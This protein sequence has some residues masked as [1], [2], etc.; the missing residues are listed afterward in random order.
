MEAHTINN[1]TQIINYH[2]SKHNTDIAVAA[3][4]LD[5][6]RKNYKKVLYFKDKPKYDGSAVND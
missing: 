1:D 6:K 5:E 3:P 2:R 4:K